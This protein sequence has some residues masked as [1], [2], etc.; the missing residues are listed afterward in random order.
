L[1]ICSNVIRPIRSLALPAV[2]GLTTVTGRV[3][4]LCVDAAD[5]T[6]AHRAV[7]R[8]TCDRRVGSIGFLPGF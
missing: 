5:G 3:G 2:K 8:A 6:A 1:D 4:Q 7:A